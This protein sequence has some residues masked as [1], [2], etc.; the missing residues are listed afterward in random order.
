MGIEVESYTIKNWEV[1]MVVSILNG[2][3]ETEAETKGTAG[4]T[5][6]PRQ[7]LFGSDEKGSLGEHYEQNGW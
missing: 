2:K 1:L 7:P 5:A 3:A 4:M 6:P